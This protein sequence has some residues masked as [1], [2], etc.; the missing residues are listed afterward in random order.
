MKVWCDQIFYGKAN[1]DKEGRNQGGQL[2]LG[3]VDSLKN[4]YMMEKRNYLLHESKS[5]FGYLSKILWW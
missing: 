1:N 3:L 4:T 5:R 2:N